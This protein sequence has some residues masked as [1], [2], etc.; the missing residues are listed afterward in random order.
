L[1]AEYAAGVS[2][3]GFDAFGFLLVPHFDRVVSQAAYYFVIV[4]L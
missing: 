3:Q 1:E 2:A 4:V